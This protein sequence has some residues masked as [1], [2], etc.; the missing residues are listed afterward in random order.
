M[1]GIAGNDRR[2]QGQVLP[3]HRFEGVSALKHALD[4]ACMKSRILPKAA[5]KEIWV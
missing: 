3:L 1:D 5:R 4:S 2:P